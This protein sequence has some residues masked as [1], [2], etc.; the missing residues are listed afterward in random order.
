MSRNF[1]AGSRNMADAAR[2]LLRRDCEAGGFSFES[3]ATLSDRFSLFVKFAK[4]QG[5]VRMERIE[6]AHAIAY[7]RDLATQVEVGQMKSSYAQNLVS[8]VN[9]VMSSA[10][11]GRWRSVSPTKDCGIQ[12][13]SNVRVD[14]P[15]GFQLEKFDVAIQALDD[16]GQAY[17]KCIRDFGLR[18]KEAALLDCRK[19]LREAQSRGEVI[20]SRGTKGGKTRVVK[21]TSQRQLATLEAA[22]AL[23]GTEKNLILPGVSWVRFQ[24]GALRKIRETLQAHG[25]T[26][27]HD[28]RASYACARYEQI[29]GLLPPVFSLKISNRDLDMEARQQIGV[30][31]GHERIDVVN[32]YVGGRK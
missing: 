18:T 8:A 12:R 16:R 4:G 17:T 20:V 9:T 3:V 13:R 29:T 21:L 23:Q 31:L 26:K 30:E 19:A 10:T 25:I 1:G 11:T 6:S 7:G 2:L 27:L 15:T 22:A 32:G 5:I 28:L 24:S 14:A